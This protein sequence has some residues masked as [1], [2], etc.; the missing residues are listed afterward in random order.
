MRGFL[1]DALK[2]LTIIAAIWATF[3]FASADEERKKL[4]GDHRADFIGR[5]EE[6]CGKTSAVAKVD[7][8]R[9]TWACGC[10]LP[11]GG[12]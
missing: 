6:R 8:E 4:I 2:V 3:M 12:R 1:A 7:G 9:A 5:C 11:E 10:I